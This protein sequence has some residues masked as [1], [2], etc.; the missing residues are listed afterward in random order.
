[1]QWLGK[2]S[3][4]IT[5]LALL[6]LTSS[7]ALSADL[8]QNGSAP[9]YLDAKQPIAARVDDLI[10]RMTLEEKASQLVNQSRAI[11]RLGIPAYNWWNEALHGVARS[12]LA[13]VFPEPVG[14]AASFDPALIHNMAV[15][16]GTEA[17]V[18]YNI[19]GRRS[20][21]HEIYQGLTFWSP[22]INIFRDPRWGRGQ[23]TYGEDPFLTGEMGKAFVTGMQGDDPKYLRTVA[24]PKHYRG[25]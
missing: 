25:A 23:E 18:K 24:T 22:N 1:M 21:D 9:I 13:T 14:L 4:T 15:A 16:I 19:A 3:L 5:A 6:G 10:S 2:K 8:P 7:S 20:T 17:R 11:P 12:G